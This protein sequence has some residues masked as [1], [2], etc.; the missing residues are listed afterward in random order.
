MTTPP[1]IEGQIVDSTGDTVSL[2]T[3]EF[4]GRT[5]PVL[6][7]D[8]G[9]T[10]LLIEAEQWMGRAK[11]SMKALGDLDGKA[12]DDPAVA[13]ARKLTQRGLTHVGRLQRIIGSLF[14]NP[15]DWDWI[16]DGLAGR[17][18]DWHEVAEL[19]AQIIRAHNEASEMKPDNREERRAV[20]KRRGRR[21]A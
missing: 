4:R 14:T 12:K 10:A 16:C 2:V 17:E 5:M 7:P 1:A 21:T 15:E 19:P 20:A 13:E 11:H 6:A 3:I 9:Q 8:T 18:I